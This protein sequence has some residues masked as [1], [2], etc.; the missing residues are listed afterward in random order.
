M[1][2][3]EHAKDAR[4]R[5]FALIERACVRPVRRR[6]TKPT[7][8]SQLRRLEGKG[9]RAGVKAGRKPPGDGE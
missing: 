2:F 4:D 3:I 1:V 6:A 9:K 8:G 7:F 5:L